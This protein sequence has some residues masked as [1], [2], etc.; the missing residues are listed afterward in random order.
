[1]DIR[2]LKYLCLA[3]LIITTSCCNEDSSIVDLSDITF[4]PVPYSLRVPEQFPQMP[5]PADNPLTQEGVALGRMLFYEKRLSGDNTMSCATCHLPQGSFT[6]NKAR[7]IG[8]DGIAGRRSSM[9][10]LNIGYV[11]TGL[12]WDGR[13]ATLEDQ[14]LIPIEDPIELHH[15]WDDVEETLRADETYPT[16]FRKAFG[17]K[18]RSEITRFLAAKAMAQFQRTIVSSGLSKY[19]RVINGVAVFTDQELIGHD[20]F[21]DINPDISRHAECGHCHNAPLF[22]TNEFFNNGLDNTDLSLNDAGRKE[23]TGNNFDNGLF[24]TPTLRNI[25]QSA[26]FM[27]DGRFKTLDEV[28]DHYASGGHP[29]RNVSPLLRKLNL[30]PDDRAALVAFIKT[31]EDPSIAT[32]PSY[33]DPF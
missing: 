22:T 16:L 21:F 26:P 27:H 5:I 20:I 24:R 23:V 19:D 6:D 33:Q 25:F 13:I 18:T 31:L 17:I 15:N 8:I 14:A 32:N 3:L 10:L 28:V 7:S 30:T 4:E 29:S 1:M 12:F 11:T 9:S 2:I